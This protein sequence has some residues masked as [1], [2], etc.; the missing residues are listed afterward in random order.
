MSVIRDDSESTVPAQ[1]LSAQASGPQ[2]MPPPQGSLISL[3]SLREKLTEVSRT[4]STHLK[5]ISEHIGP[6]AAARDQLIK[7]E[8][9]MS[10][11]V[12]SLQTIQKDAGEI[13]TTMSRTL[14]EILGAMQGP[15]RKKPE[16]E[17]ARPRSQQDSA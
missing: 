13:R 3:Q 8:H 1:A 9:E 16:S 12:K 10:D 2:L 11:Q 14:E 6:L 17:V 4:Y 5:I 7:I 15:D